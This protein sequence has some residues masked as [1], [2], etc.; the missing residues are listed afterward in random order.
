MQFSCSVYGQI[1]TAQPWRQYS[2]PEEAR[3]A[4]EGERQR[5]TKWSQTG[6]NIIRHRWWNRKWRRERSS[7]PWRYAWSK[8]GREN[9]GWKT[10]VWRER[11]GEKACEHKNNQGQR[12]NKWLD[13]GWGVKRWKWLMGSLKVYCSGNLSSLFISKNDLYFSEAR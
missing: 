13:D 9:V 4:C 11:E 10:A 7:Q 5:H 6:S 12:C 2:P 8:V 1:I 3:A